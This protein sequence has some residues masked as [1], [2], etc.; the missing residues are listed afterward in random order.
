MDL[1]LKGR[2]GG[3]TLLHLMFCASP[4]YFQGLLVAARPHLGLDEQRH[5]VQAITIGI[6][7]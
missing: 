5:D 7:W 3:Q 6:E 2:E 4:S 1:D